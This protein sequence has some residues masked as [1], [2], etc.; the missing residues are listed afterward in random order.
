MRN[1]GYGNGYGCDRRWCWFA[2]WFVCDDFDV[3]C[4]N[5][6]V[7]SC[8]R[9]SH[10]ASRNLQVLYSFCLFMIVSFVCVCPCD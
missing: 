5:S 3:L 4:L 6:F 9:Y 2:V 1:C 7:P 10:F 8:P